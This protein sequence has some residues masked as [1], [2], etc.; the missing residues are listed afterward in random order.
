MRKIVIIGLSFLLGGT[1][2]ISMQESLLGVLDNKQ[3]IMKSARNVLTN[4]GDINKAD[5]Q[6]NSLLHKA[7]ESS[8]GVDVVDFLLRKGADPEKRNYVGLTP[9]DMA[10]KMGVEYNFSDEIAIKYGYNC[11]Q[12]FEKHGLLFFPA[13]GYYYDNPFQ[14]LEN[15]NQDWQKLLKLNENTLE[16]RFAEKSLARL[17]GAA[18]KTWSH[19]RSTS[20]SSCG[21][22]KNDYGWFVKYISP[23]D[24]GSFFGIQI[25]KEIDAQLVSKCV[26][27]SSFIDE[28]DY[29][30]LKDYIHTYPFIISYDRIIT[31]DMV[32][33]AIKNRYDQCL[34]LLLDNA[35]NLKIPR[36]EQ[37]KDG[38]TLLHQAVCYNNVNAIRMLINHGVSFMVNN[39][40][41]QSPIEYAIATKREK[42][43]KVFNLLLLE[44]LYNILR[45]DNYDEFGVL[46]THIPD[47]NMPC[48]TGKRTILH[49]AVE[50]DN[51]A[52]KKYIIK[53]LEAGANP[54]ALN[55][56]KKTPLFY[57]L[58][59]QYD[60]CEILLKA[61]ACINAQRPEDMG[62]LECAVCL[63]NMTLVE[64]L[65]RH[66]GV[67][68]QRIIGV[69]RNDTL[70]QLLQKKHK[71]QECCLCLTHPEDMLDI[72]CKKRH[73]GD[74]L[75]K[76]CYTTKTGG[77]CPLC[78]EKLGEYG[79]Y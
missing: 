78:P 41:N 6:G 15:K 54:N 13:D 3:S 7:V 61:G 11:L 51:L 73:F 66:D 36:C 5:S 77:T 29:A 26:Q 35:I 31:W 46:L 14:F 39:K 75:C 63:N 33:K 53:L 70:R 18:R 38:M 2:I 60:V 47:I 64:L 9:F 19:G 17:F 20:V 79:S 69:A 44:M 40:A 25:A 42:C 37:C 32:N 76:E 65:L 10:V 68:T 21:I 72:P 58:S 56:N 22:I 27:G 71:T 43:V 16:L 49:K 45:D 4:G 67:V 59:K 55:G 50:M 48:F 8:A 52:V 57:S 24:L 23:K 1:S 28:N 62:S 30:G 74:F 34:E 12:A